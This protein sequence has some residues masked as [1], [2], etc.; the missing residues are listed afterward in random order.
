MA[1]LLKILLALPLLAC[2]GVSGLA[3]EAQEMDAEERVLLAGVPHESL[4]YGW[5]ISL[6]GL[7]LLLQHRGEAVTLDE[8]SVLSGDAFH[9][10]FGV[11]ADT[12][13]EL[14]MPT[15]PLGNA[16]AAL[17]YSYEWWITE[18][19]LRGHLT[20]AVP[21][22][23][24]RRA[25]TLEVLKRLQAQIDRG[26][27]VLVGGVSHQ[28]CGNWSLVIGY[29]RG[30]TSLCH[31]G[32]DNEPAGTWSK[33]WGLT[34]P[35]NDR[36]GV[37][38]YW[39]GRPRGTV[40]PGYQGGWLVNPVFVLGDQHEAPDPNTLTRAVLQRA[41]ALHQAESVDFFAGR[42]YYGAEAYQQW[43]ASMAD[44]GGFA[45]LVLDEVVRGRAA[46]AAFCEQRAGLH[47]R[48]GSA[49]RQAAAAYRQEVEA[50]RAGFADFIPFRWDNQAR[51]R[52]GAAEQRRSAAQAVARMLEHERAAVAAVEQALTSL[53]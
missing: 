32:L 46:A 38:G 29:D 11:G 40:V 49:L 48:A 35:I 41:V 22:E 9:L 30:H 50:A 15:E 6:R 17:G 5:D 23:A 24:R 13:P 1:N 12:Y 45:D 51:V 7:H 44:S 25:L 43:A 36:D 34:A 19:G 28:G 8:L 21:D 26:R 4:V 20:N 27:P 37:P 33:I 39:N 2:S 18:S 14:L 53:E 31:N 3:E 42:Y 16:A 47:P 52:W 10:C